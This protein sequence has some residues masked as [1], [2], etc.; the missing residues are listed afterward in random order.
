[1]FNLAAF[2]SYVLVVSF[3]P[4]PNVV[5][6]MVNANKF[7]YRKTFKFLLGIFLGFFIIMFISNYF[8]LLLFSLIPR[9]KTFMGILGAAY[10]TFL[11]ILIIKS[12]DTSEEKVDERLN[13]FFAGLSLQFINPK[14]ILYAI[15]VS[16]NFI[17][18]YYKSN[19]VLFFFTVFLSSLIFISVSLWA[20]FGLLFKIFLSKH[21][22]PFNFVMGLLLL[23]GAISISGIFEL[24]H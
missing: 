14:L 9:I 11:A 18:P 22:K 6:S 5:L 17:I 2:L 19:M 23:Y 7:G 4:G 10:M 24:F 3:T 21:R 15:T 12:K 20:L 16:S 8:N 13:S 1:M